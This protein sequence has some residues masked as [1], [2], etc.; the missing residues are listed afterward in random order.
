MPASL[1]IKIVSGGQTG[2]DRA[3]LDVAL[4]LGIPAGGWCPRGRLAEDG[5]IPERYPLR[6]LR[7]GGYRERTLRNVVDSDATVLIYF[8]RTTGGTDL[9]RRYCMQES[10][11]VLLLDGAGMQAVESADQ[12]L[13]FVRAH[14]VHVLNVAGPRASGDDRCYAYAYDVMSH[15][16]KGYTRISC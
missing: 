13:Q 10:K 6:E 12:L 11:P 2:V 15:F 8:S 7:G 4:E 3:A 9:T 5:V 14:G 1:P 16:L